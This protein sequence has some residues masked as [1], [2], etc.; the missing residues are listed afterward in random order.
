MTSI[1][2]VGVGKIARDQH[3]PA[4]EASPDFTLTATASRNGQVE[5]IPA[6]PDIDAMIAAEPGLQAISLCQPP[7][8]RHAAA[9]SAI[10]AGKHVFLEKP[11]GATLSEVEDLCAA[12]D[13]EGVTLFASWHSRWA[14]AVE[15]ARA[16]LSTRK[17]ER[18][19]IA[20]KEDVRKWHPGQDWIWQP[21]G[22]G[23]FD[24]G[25][26]A[27]SILTRILSGPV[28]LEAA[29]M[30]VP[31]NRAAPIAADLTM[32]SVDGAPIH[33]VFDWRQTGPQ[34]WDISV[35]TDGGTLLL[36]D[37]G[38]RLTI[39]GVA[40]DVPA[41]REYPALYDRFAQLIAQA[42]SDVDLAPLTIVADAFM[43]GARVPTDAFED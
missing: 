10:A 13:A 29:T 24:P 16:W 28:R 38:N 23:V 30:A 33:A 5:G 35:E 40:H 8:A 32:R 22:F 11:P 4:I 19:E 17:I 9:R 25:I 12:A 42:R 7:S 37:G 3:I 6:Y 34:S 43:V 36:A 26:N 20:W 18:V 21:G 39:D 41:D 15:P 2:I 1:A 14:A 27:L 31:A